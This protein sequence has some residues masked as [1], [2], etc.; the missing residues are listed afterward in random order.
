M[1]LPMMQSDQT[2]TEC[3]HGITLVELLVAL[4]L[5]SLLVLVSVSWMTTMIS[6]QN[7]DLQD[8]RWEW[9]ASMVIDQVGRDLMQ[10]ELID[11][12][13]RRGEPRVWIED[14]DLF[15]RTI[16]AGQLATI[17]YQY[18]LSGGEIN[19]SVLGSQVDVDE[20]I[21]LIGLVA[22][23][24]FELRLPDQHRARPELF[25]AIESIHSQTRMRSFTL[26][27]EDVRQ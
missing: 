22:S 10:V 7:R 15:I 2:S 18:L 9:A 26:D 12:T 14:D 13:R 23:L 20:G 21:P 8:A 1:A 19:R 27:Q 16:E 25:M 11:D 5:L 3:P 17:R 4:S 24:R 6:R